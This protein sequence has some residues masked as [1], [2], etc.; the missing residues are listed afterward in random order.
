MKLFDFKSLKRSSW[1]G[2]ENWIKRKSTYVRRDFHAKTAIPKEDEQWGVFRQRMFK[3]TSKSWRIQSIASP[4]V[5]KMGESNGRKNG[6]TSIR[7]SRSPS[8]RGG[9]RTSRRGTQWLRESLESGSD[10][11]W[12]AISS[13]YGWSSSNSFFKATRDPEVT[14]RA[15]LTRAYWRH[16]D[17]DITMQISQKAY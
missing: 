5:S 4:K 6:M 9:C 12:R 15:S 16:K 10:D 2:F 13:S 1:A 11:K 3:V 8:L 14:C 7:R 17:Y